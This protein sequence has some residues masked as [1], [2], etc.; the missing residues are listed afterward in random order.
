MVVARVA[1]QKDRDDVL[2]LF[3]KGWWP[4]GSLEDVQKSPGASYWNKKQDGEYAVVAEDKG[5]VVGNLSFVSF[6][7]TIRGNTLNIAGVWG[8]TTE[9]HYRMKGAVR[10]MFKVAFPMM[11][12]NGYYLSILDPFYTPFYEKFGYAQAEE[13]SRHIFLPKQL[14]HVRGRN[15]VTTRHVTDPNEATEIQKIQKTMSR[16]GSRIFLP[17][18][19]FKRIIQKNYVHIL[20]QKEIPVGTVKFQ[21]EEIADEK[22]KLRVDYVAYTK[23]DI[24]PSII[25]LIAQYAVQADEV[26]LTCD[27]EIPF[28]HFL[29][30]NDDMQS[31]E[32]GRM[33]MRV[34]D[35]RAYCENITIPTTA[36]EPIIVE[37]VD[38][39]CS[40]NNGVYSLTPKDGKLEV[41]NLGSKSESKQTPEVC[42]S[43]F[44][45]SQVISGLSPATML[46]SIGELD[47]S[48]ETAE[49]L[50]AIWPAESFLSYMRF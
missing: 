18:D 19:V 29:V 16:F 28:R 40:W 13:R 33:I 50:E 14:K 25:E 20:E 31:L 36:L 35:F 11:R 17:I 24:L 1:T 3:W 15:D 43:D 38:E 27:R 44:K 34:I 45:L 47:C 21:F 12:E 9:P 7:N 2:R 6:P 39:Y 42:M 46:H 26:V 41:E 48:K 8:V 10:E 4:A 32:R 5:R 22:Y 49:K 37:L 23:N 30:D